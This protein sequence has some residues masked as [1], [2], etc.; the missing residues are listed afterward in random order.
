MFLSDISS[1]MFQ[2]F[3]LGARG[4]PAGLILLPCGPPGGYIGGLAS[5]LKQGLLTLKAIN[6]S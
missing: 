2:V 4:R 5:E 3:A 6:C 1:P